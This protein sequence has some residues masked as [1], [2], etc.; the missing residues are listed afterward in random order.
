MRGKDPSARLA[1]P[2]MSC[3]A[4]PQYREDGVTDQQVNKADVEAFAGKMVGIL[5]NAGVALMTSI[6]H[7]TGL[8]DTMAGLP[9]ST[10]GQIATAAG[11]NERYVREW[12]GAMVCGGIVEIDPEQ[13]TSGY[14]RNGPLALPGRPV[15]TTSPHR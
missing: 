6:G 9:P 2:L 1:W 15:R 14:R 10:G 11:L 13:Q 5:N 3:M 4:R 12:L 7:Q 8:F